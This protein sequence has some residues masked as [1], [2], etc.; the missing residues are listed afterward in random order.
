MQRA[1]ER[2][3]EQTREMIKEFE[4]EAKEILNEDGEESE[5]NQQNQSELKVRNPIWGRFTITPSNV[6]SLSHSTEQS[7]D[8]KLKLVDSTFQSAKVAL[9]MGHKTAMSG[10]ITVKTDEDQIEDNVEEKVLV[11]GNAKNESINDFFFAQSDTNKSKVQISTIQSNET[12]SANSTQSQNIMESNSQIVKSK[13]IQS[14]KS[15]LSQTD[16]S[17]S[18]VDEEPNPW[19]LDTKPSKSKPKSKSQTITKNNENAINKSSDI[20]E[21]KTTKITNGKVNNLCVKPINSTADTI[22]SN[23]TKSNAKSLKSNSIEANTSNSQ[24]SNIRNSSLLS[25]DEKSDS[26]NEINLLSSATQRDLVT[27]A[28]ATDSATESDFVKQKM[29]LIQNELSSVLQ[30]HSDTQSSGVIPG[31]GNWVGDGA[32]KRKLTAKQRR[33][34]EEN[35]RKLAQ[36]TKQALDSRRDAK[37]SKVVISEQTD[38]KLNKYLVPQIP[39]PFTNEMEYSHSLSQPMG[40]EWNTLNS[41][42]KSVAPQIITR[43]GTVIEP[44]KLSKIQKLKADE[45]IIK[46]QIED[47]KEKKQIV[48]RKLSQRKPLLS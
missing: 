25:S 26:E 48:K 13:H 28:F 29:E 10:N 20:N 6:T 45:L 44:M 5:Q 23:S 8:Q 7:D 40:N 18:A 47:L 16:Q 36:I 3:K 21:K 37:L 39:F 12:N 4:I 35:T 30:R 38:R 19:A 46:Q 14:K 43:M 34:I 42:Q 1:L 2:Q 9:S 32:P 27:R 41:H 31:W 11:L 33:K 15:K 17:H 24:S 22:S